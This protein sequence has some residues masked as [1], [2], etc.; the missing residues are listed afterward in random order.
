MIYDK[1]IPGIYHL[2]GPDPNQRVTGG[3]STGGQR[4][5]SF[6]RPCLLFKHQR[7]QRHWLN[8]NGTFRFFKFEF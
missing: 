7:H 5:R 1:Y 2:L 4:I 3:I 6:Y 8:A